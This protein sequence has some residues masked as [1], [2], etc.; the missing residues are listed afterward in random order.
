MGNLLILAALAVIGW[1]V[2]RGLTSS[3]TGTEVTRRDAKT[4]ERDPSTGIYRSR[5][6]DGS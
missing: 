2:W 4:L 3:G 1:L 5:E 6:R